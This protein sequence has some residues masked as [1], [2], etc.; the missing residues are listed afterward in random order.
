MKKCNVCD[1]KISDFAV[2]CPY[3]H[4]T[5]NQIFPDIQ[6]KKENCTKQRAQKH[7]LISSTLSIVVIA[8]FCICSF[9][10]APVYSTLE[11]ILEVLC[12]CY[13]LYINVKYKTI[14]ISKNK[15]LVFCNI[16][17]CVL[18]SFVKLVM[19]IRL[20]GIGMWFTEG[21]HIRYKLLII[22]PYISKAIL[23]FFIVMDVACLIRNK[24]KK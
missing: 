5:Q 2:T 6:E 11:L 7:I 15:I 16:T 10:Y 19:D 23:L 13:S 3:C 4:S 21:I 22:L 12:L 18:L 9:P 1:K 17:A 14:L 8:F 20:Y 24:I